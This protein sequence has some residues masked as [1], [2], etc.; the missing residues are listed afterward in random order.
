MSYVLGA[1]NV[2]Q[3]LILKAQAMHFGVTFW[4]HSQK[5][6]SSR[7]NVLSGSCLTAGGNAA[8]FINQVCIMLVNSF[9]MPDGIMNRVGQEA[10]ACAFSCFRACNIIVCSS[11]VHL[12]PFFALAISRASLNSGLSREHVCCHMFPPAH[13]FL[14]SLGNC[15]GN[16]D[17]E[18]TTRDIS[19]DYELIKN[20]IQPVQWV[21]SVYK[22]SNAIGT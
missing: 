17:D 6:T 3:N 9:A 22:S 21:S 16:T 18:A 4:Y 12:V 13:V 14:S 5:S 20:S 10:Q 8:L 19:K 1:L 11:G 15:E 7:F 2:S